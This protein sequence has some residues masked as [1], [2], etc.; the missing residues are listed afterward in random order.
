MEPRIRKSIKKYFN[1]ATLLGLN[2]LFSNINTP[3]TQSTK[4]KKR[5]ITKDQQYP[6]YAQPSPMPSSF[7]TYL[8]VYGH[9]KYTYTSGT[10]A[11]NAAFYNSVQSFTN[12][13]GL[14]GV[15]AN[16]TFPNLA[17]LNTIYDKIR[18]KSIEVIFKPVG[19]TTQTDE[20]LDQSLLP[21]PI[22]VALPQTTL[23]SPTLNS[24]LQIKPSIILATD[25]AVLKTHFPE[26]LPYKDNDEST[27][28]T[29]MPSTA[30]LYFQP[31]STIAPSFEYYITISYEVE[32]TKQE[33]KLVAYST[34]H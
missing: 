17:T 11:F 1:P 13:T 8:R 19:S 9:F 4:R 22:A 20:T 16:A 30:V 18:M 31:L 6:R 12:N 3:Y 34:I 26:P 7:T 15:Y 33:S 23:S 21:T 14:G 29:L 28:A 24:V 25:S 10:Q 5:Y 2:K 32:L 27:Q